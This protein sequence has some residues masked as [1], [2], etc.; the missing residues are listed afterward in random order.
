MRKQAVRYTISG[1]VA[2][3]L[4]IALTIMA[5]WLAGRRYVRADWT[6]TQLYTLSEKT[7]NIVSDLGEEIRVIVFMTPATSM[8]DQVHELLE[9][10]KAA[11]DEIT[12]EFIDPDKAIGNRS[13]PSSWRSS[14]A[15]RWRTRW[16]LSSMT[17]P[18]T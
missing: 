1:V 16:S 6:S 4:V 18:S 5:N 12:V 13:R 17:A 10:Y 3:V 7:E 8:Y 14:L 2:V 9:R 15:S 11:S